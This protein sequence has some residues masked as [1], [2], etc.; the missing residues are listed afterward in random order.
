M[1]FDNFILIFQFFCHRNIGR[2]GI[3]IASKI[4]DIQISKCRHRQPTDGLN[5]KLYS[6]DF[7]KIL[8]N[9]LNKEE[10]LSILPKD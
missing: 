7:G 3:T 1:F 5:D 9:R 8:R 10:R 6:A 2:K 4:I